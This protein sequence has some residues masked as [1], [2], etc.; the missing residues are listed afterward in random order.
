MKSAVEDIMRSAFLLAEKSGLKHPFSKSG[1]KAGRAWFEGFMSRNPQLS[2]RQAQSLSVARATSANKE[3]ISDLFG[4]LGALFAKLNIISK[5]MLVYNV[6]ITVVTKPTGVITQVGRKAVYSIAAAE[7][8][9]THT[10]MTCGSA[11]GHVLPPMIIFP[12]ERLSNKQVHGSV[13]GML[14]ACSSN[15]WI[16][17]VLYEK[18]FDFL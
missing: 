2:I 3:T 17:R 7:K 11:S 8:G 12:R 15:G 4:K 9:K 6:G 5:P 14:F 18:W 13:P 10:I 16:N 1:G